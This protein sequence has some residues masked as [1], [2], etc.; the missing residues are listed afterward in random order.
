MNL[1]QN[2]DRLDHAVNNAAFLR[3]VNDFPNLGLFQPS[4]DKAPWHWQA[5]IDYGAQQTINFWP[6]TLKAQREGF[7]S[8]AGADAIRAVI[9]QAQIDAAE[10]PFDVF[11]GC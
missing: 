2:P 9:E 1:Y 5:V 11:E 6:H 10:E 7:K 8:V 4:P 3:V